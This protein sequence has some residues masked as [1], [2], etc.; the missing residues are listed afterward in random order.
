MQISVVIPTCNRKTGLLYLLHD[1]NRS[2]YP[3][4]EV[5]I[6]DSGEDRLVP[7]DYSRFENIDIRYMASE[8]SVCIQ[9]NK[10]IRAARAPWIF[11]CDDDIEMPVSYLR[12]LMDHAS[13]HPEA[14]AISGLVLQK[15]KEVWQSS[16]PLRSSRELVWKFVFQLG[17]WGEI[18]CPA[19]YPW[20]R[21]I[22]NYYQRR[23]NHVSKAGW[24]VLTD[25]SGD[26]F[27]TPLYGLGAS[28][29]KKEWLLESPYDEVLDPH[30]IGDNY[31]VAMG[32]PSPG[33][34]VLN[35]AFVY[36]HQEPSNRLQKPL[37]YFRRVL[38]LDYFLRVRPQQRPVKKRWLLW[39][40]IGNFLAFVF[41]GDRNMMRS[42]LQS[43]RVVASGHNP[44]YE[45]ARDNLR[46]VEPLLRRAA[47]GTDAF[48]RIAGTA[49]LPAGARRLT[50]PV[51]SRI[52][53]V[54]FIL[55]LL[56]SG[57][58]MGH[59]E[60][61]ADELHSWNIAK[62]SG[63]YPDLLVNKKY[64][65]H[66]AGWYTILWTLSK[67]T[68]RLMYMQAV[69]WC[70]ASLVVFLVIFRSPFP[71]IVRVMIPFGYFFLFE[72]AVFSRNYAAG[73]LLSFCICYIL[74]KDFTCKTLLY[75][76]L[77]FCLSNFHLL[78][79]VLAASLHL[80]FLLFNREQ[81]VN[82][83]MILVHALAGIIVL[84]PAAW[85]IIPPPDS[86][87]N[88]HF[89]LSRWDFHQFIVTGDV[90]LRSFL[91][92]PAWWNQHFWNTEFL[93]EAGNTHPLLQW[94]DPILS[95]AMVAGTIFLL[96]KNK[97]SLA[98][99][100][101]NLVLSLIIS[102]V[103]FPLTSTRY[104]GFLYIS[105]I[106]AFWL[107]C[108]ETPL[109]GRV[110]RLFILLLALQVPAG[111]F[112]VVKDIRLP[113]SNLYAV[114]A[115][116]E[117]VPVGEKLVTDYWTMNAVVAFTDHPA[118]CVDMGRSISF[119]RWAS[120]IAAIQK[121]P[122]RY[123]GGISALFAREGLRSVYMVSMASPQALDKVDSLLSRSFQVELV[124]KKEGAIE[125]GS[126]L[127]LYQIRSF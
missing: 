125:K 73:I 63:S 115:M 110:R 93:L 2:D 55:Y 43:I 112:A 23:G 59:H 74:R 53:W 70:I 7:A 71:R 18:D 33:I 32:F 123:S 24:P 118:Y 66:P 42:A 122:H 31:G 76:L 37:Q 127:Y 52:N 54:V 96:A 17:V 39:S 113:F 105:F 77:L 89:F 121:N 87:M 67:F 40:L 120:D 126:N 5:I 27:S 114:K 86:Q 68:H 44:Y 94:V 35:D 91:P 3:L 19:N 12:Q 6:V 10:G 65:G 107:Y 109:T 48:G 75:Y 99:F 22:K 80:Y 88:A 124:D 101:C 38:A 29:V 103:V 20:I 61:W 81:R 64:E 85:S 82:P 69:Q 34:H 57:Y 28:L 97:K 9:R 15:E 4:L 98:L 92:M 111:I 36:H 84:L 119:V 83:Y 56:I 58:T 25:F 14:G 41:A 49:G 50:R 30:G 72:Y 13:L 78:T 21:K 117:E 62:G 108:Y 79:L 60:L 90:A 46:V 16:Y 104:A 8:R 11:L 116:M 1:L 106:V 51:S 95:A 26:Y 102:V 45:G 47:A 100:L